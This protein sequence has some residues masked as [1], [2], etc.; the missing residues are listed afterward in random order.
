MSRNVLEGQPHT[1]ID[2]LESFF[3]VLCYVVAGYSRPVTPKIPLPE[4]LDAW[5]R[6]FARGVKHGW[7]ITLPFD[8]EVSSWFGHALRA[9]CVRLHSFFETRNREA[10]EARDEGRIPPRQVASTD[11]EEFINHIRQAISEMDSDDFDLA[12]LSD[13]PSVSTKDK[14]RTPREECS[15]ESEQPRPPRRARRN[16]PAVAPVVR[17]RRTTAHYRS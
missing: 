12:R 10:R 14:R 8:L 1:Y 2:D 7:I 16:P 4:I 3:Y 6:G 17:P 9:L 11:Y 15:D 13:A 5:N